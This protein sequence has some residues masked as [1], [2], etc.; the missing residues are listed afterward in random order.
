[1]QRKLKTTLSR[2]HEAATIESFRKDPA[3]AA[4]YVNAVLADGD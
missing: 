3:F 1:M 4:E 2:S